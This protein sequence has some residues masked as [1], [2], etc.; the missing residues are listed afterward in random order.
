MGGGVSPCCLKLEGS[1]VAPLCLL[2]PGFYLFIYFLLPPP[3]PWFFFL[4]CMHIHV[5]VTCSFE[6]RFGPWE[7]PPLRSLTI[8]GPGGSLLRRLLCVSLAHPGLSYQFFSYLFS[9]GI[10]ASFCN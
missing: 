1:A 8:G 9:Y 10:Q 4:G 2:H 7:P 6:V 5:Q 3:P